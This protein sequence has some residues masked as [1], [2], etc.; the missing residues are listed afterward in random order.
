[1]TPETVLIQR[2]IKISPLTDYLL[3]EGQIK[4]L[5]KENNWNNNTVEPH[6]FMQ[7][8]SFGGDFAAHISCALGVKE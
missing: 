4:R 6:G 7:T 5:K 2:R 3:S 8:F 1:M